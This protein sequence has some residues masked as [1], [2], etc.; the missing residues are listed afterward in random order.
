MSV[1][2]D[3]LDELYGLAP[4]EFTAARDARA[5]TLRAAGDRESAAAVK[6]LPRPSAAAWA[7]NRLIRRDPVR[8]YEVLDVGED[9][10]RA[11]ADL[12]GVRLREMSRRR[13]A[14]V[15]SAVRAAEEL[16]REAGHPLSGAV[17][18]QVEAALQAATVDPAAGAR[19]REGRLAESLQPAG[20]GLGD[21]LPDL[22]ATSAP[23]PTPGDG[24][25][26]DGDVTE[27]GVETE[28]TE[29]TETEAV[30]AVVESARRRAREAQDAARRADEAL[31]AAEKHLD[32]SLDAQRRADERVRR[33]RRELREAEH[34]ASAAE[35]ATESAGRERDEAA[36]VAQRAGRAL[37]AARRRLQ[38]L[39]LPVD[40]DRRS[41]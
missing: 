39:G 19:V 26:T 17:S 34:D 9:L 7:V 13:H 14:V 5:R 18:R 10:R 24:D 15:S 1:P 36:R 27:E 12:D 11:Q 4:Q 22:P 25:V 8:V 16:A 35:Q 23:A 38:A 20:F 3:V 33:L 28:H 40:A 32:D 29:D 41:G 37:D 2:P 21:S 30:R 6:K 31:A